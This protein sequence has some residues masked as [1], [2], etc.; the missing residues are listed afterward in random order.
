MAICW[1]GIDST[2]RHKL[3][4]KM[5]IGSREATE[6][7]YFPWQPWYGTFLQLM[8]EIPIIKLYYEIAIEETSWYI[9]QNSSKVEVCFKFLKLV[10]FSLEQN[11]FC[12]ATMEHI[13]HITCA[14][15]CLYK[16]RMNSLWME[17]FPQVQGGTH[18]EANRSINHNVFPAD[19][20]YLLC[21]LEPTPNKKMTFF[22]ICSAQHNF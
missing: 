7:L 2:N 4:Y 3:G 17:N 1:D 5:L 9:P 21:C 8:G 13:V 20:L 11:V 12:L 10:S 16:L 6:G 19:N 14:I 18:P 22:I 15:K